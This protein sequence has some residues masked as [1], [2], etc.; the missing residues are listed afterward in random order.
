MPVT[1]LSAKTESDV[2]PVASRKPRNE[3]RIVSA[4]TSGG[5]SAATSPRKTQNDSAISSGNAISSAR[6]RSSSTVRPTCS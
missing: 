4:P 6:T 5:S 3:S 1:R 2:T